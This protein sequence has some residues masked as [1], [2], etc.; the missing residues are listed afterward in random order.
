MDF[1]FI[2]DE[3]S[4]EYRILSFYI[5]AQYG[6]RTHEPQILYLGLIV[7]SIQINDK[8]YLDNV[9]IIFVKQK[10]KFRCIISLDLNLT[11]DFTRGI[12]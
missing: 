7:F 9:Y 12:K 4:A 8:Q 3:D 5:G 6:T 11:Y 10:L 1:Y 2:I